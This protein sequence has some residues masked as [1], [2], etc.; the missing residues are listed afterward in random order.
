MY[1]KKKNYI[2]ISYLKNILIC[3]IIFSSENE[4]WFN[5]VIFL[6]FYSSVCNESFFFVIFSTTTRSFTPRMATGHQGDNATSTFSVSLGLASIL[7]ERDLF[8]PA[9]KNQNSKLEPA[10]NPERVDSITSDSH[11]EFTKIT[12]SSTNTT[13]SECNLSE[14]TVLPRPDTASPQLSLPH[15]FG[16][17]NTPSTSQRGLPFDHLNQGT[18]VLMDTLKH[19]GY[20]IINSRYLGGFLGSQRMEETASAPCDQGT[21]SSTA[22]VTHVTAGSIKKTEVSKI[23]S[24]IGHALPGGVSGALSQLRQSGIF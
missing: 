2:S 19:T 14:S 12:S 21:E 17:V 1:C 8:P 9:K 4:T 20:S 13:K 23:N 15:S 3:L 16:S 22:D 10:A 11:F 6:L 5:A 7:N 18:H 24:L